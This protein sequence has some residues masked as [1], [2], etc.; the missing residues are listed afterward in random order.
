MNYL[1]DSWYMAGWTAELD[2]PEQRGMVAR[3][4]CDI[5]VLLFRSHGALVALS[6]TCPH[7]FAPLNR[8]RLLDGAIQCGY[9]GLAFGADGRCVLNPHGPI[10]PAMKVR[11]F[12]VV[13]RHRAM[14]IWMGAAERADPTLL[15]DLCCLDEEQGAVNEWSHLH[16]KANYQLYV[17]NIMDL[18]HVDFLHAGIYPDYVLTGVE[19]TVE[20]DGDSIMLRWVSQQRPSRL[21]EMS[22]AFPAETLIERRGAVQW[23]APS[24]LRVTSVASAMGHAT[25]TR[26]A[27]H[28]MTPETAT[29]THYFWLFTRG[30]VRVEDEELHRR[31]NEETR[32][33]FSM[34]DSA[35]LAAVQERMGT[36]T[37]LFPLK[38]LLLRTDQAAVRVRRK[39]TALMIQQTPAA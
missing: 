38:P 16:G 34:E 33:V 11:A 35:M 6:D 3:T 17:D 2:R 5:P 22:G 21:E 12:P 4:V 13:E 20:E 27:V 10:A 14:W 26:H 9:H 30:G 15:P 36:N 18:S 39:L 32:R 29:T 7:R 24:T 19:Q 28:V 8:G 31:L 1:L 37:D 23:F 25:R